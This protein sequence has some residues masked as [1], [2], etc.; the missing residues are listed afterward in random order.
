MKCLSVCF[1]VF[2][3]MLISACSSDN[4]TPAVDQE[5]D[6]QSRDVLRW[7]ATAKNVTI[8]R[9][10][11][12]IPHIK[13]KTDADAV[14]GML[15]AQAEDDFNRIERNYINAMGRLAEDLG[16]DELYRDLR[17]KLFIQPKQI[18]KQYEES[19]EW[20]KKLM[21]AFADGLNYYL[22]T[23]PEVKPK[24]ITRFEPWMALTFSEGSI[25]GDI[26]RGVNMARLAEFYGDDMANVSFDID[27]LNTAN[28][29]NAEPG[30]SNGFAIAPSRTKN[31]NALLLVN[32]HT[33]F[34][35]RHE[36]H[37]QSEE[38]LNAYG[39]STWGQFFIYQGFN[40]RVGWMHTS[41]YVDVIDEYAET[42]I[43]RNDGL[44][45]QYGN[46]QRKLETRLIELPFKAKDGSM[47]QKQV[48]AYFTHRGPIVRSHNGKWVSVRLMEEPVKALIQSYSRTKAQN[49]DEFYA[50][51]KGL[52]NSS[53]NTVYAD[54]DGTIAYFHGNFVPRRDT[55]FDFTQPVDGSNPATDW[56]GIHPLEEHIH[57]K[58]PGNGWIQNTNNWPY[59]AAAEFSP[60]KA[61]YPAYYSGT[62]ENYRGIHA[63]N[64]LKNTTDFDVDSL[65]NAAY[66]SHLTGFDVLLPPLFEAFNSLPSSDP[67]KKALA[68]PIAALQ[69]WDNRSSVESVPTSVAVYWATDFMK[70]VRNKARSAG[71]SVYTYM[72]SAAS[73]E[74]RLMSLSAAV[75]KLKAD[76]GSWQTPWGE[77]NR[78][79]RISPNIRQHFDDDAPS[80][81]V[82]FA[83]GR[84]GA[85]AAFGQNYGQGETKRIYGTRGNSFVAAVE[86]GEKLKAKAITAGG[87]SN[88]PSSPHYNDQAAVYASG[89]L[90]DVYFYDEDI[91][92]NAEETYR[93]GQ[94]RIN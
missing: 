41:T 67:R 14:F 20:L 38:G 40:E 93:P 17:M 49:Y 27:L 89:K 88:D 10:N 32:P 86:F 35:F 66:D 24:V 51:M 47:K 85:L 79:Q 77:I 92:A 91:S 4:K 26:E 31:G 7:E 82:G 8:T 52:T 30:G 54:A 50:A 45:Y 80:L 29:L 73:H 59:S 87:L 69:A 44:Y 22:Y 56:Q 3:T 25:G 65:I 9:D 60:K 71:L 48:T 5:I 75:N 36:A 83:S 84:W 61:D 70:S 43:E 16:E 21:V 1:A 76:F 33:S 23:H 68:A 2:V 46:E 94:R 74:E 72:E 18:K 81:P 34:Y 57:I 12:G 53:N 15:Y 28:Q 78:F 39:A 55:A 62:T 90:R 63:I 19:P 58:N 11:W 13:G 37:V 42:V 64:L 6:N